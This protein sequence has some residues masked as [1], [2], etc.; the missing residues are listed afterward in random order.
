[1]RNRVFQAGRGLTPLLVLLL[2]SSASAELAVYQVRKGDSTVSFTATKWKVFKE[3]GRFREFGGTIAVDF[4]APGRSKVEL[5]VR[6]DSVD[7]GVGG[8]DS[9]LRSDDFLDVARHPKMSFVSTAVVPRGEDLFDVT[10][11]LTIHGVTKKVTVPLRLLGR[12]PGPSGSELIGF[13]TAFSIDRT[14][15]GVLGSRWSGG[16]LLIA[17]EV[18]IRLLVS[19]DRKR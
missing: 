13:E 7:T 6:T 14:A 5:E 3:Q 4:E 1:M 11:D 18:E 8:R 10:G 17:R 2:A 16:E 9:A 12:G 15:Y 19:A